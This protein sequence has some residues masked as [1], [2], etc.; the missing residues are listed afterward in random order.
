MEMTKV[1]KSVHKKGFPN[2]FGNIVYL[3]NLK[4]FSELVIELNYNQSK[5]IPWIKCK[6]NIANI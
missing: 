1:V 2:T 6:N 4:S 3:W 5:C